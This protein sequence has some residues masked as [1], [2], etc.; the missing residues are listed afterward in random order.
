MLTGKERSRAKRFMELR[1]ELY[2]GM[3]RGVQIVHNGEP[4]EAEEFEA[5]L[6]LMEESDYMRE[7]VADRSGRIIQVNYEQITQF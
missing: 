2:E 3:H 6:I 7:Y 1:E 4:I 5:V